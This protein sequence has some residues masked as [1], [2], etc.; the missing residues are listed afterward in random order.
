MPI[1]GDVWYRN[2]CSVS[3]FFHFHQVVIFTFKSLLLR[4]SL[5]RFGSASD[6]DLADLHVTSKARWKTEKQPRNL[7]VTSALGVL[8]WSPEIGPG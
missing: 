5:P 3:I 1:D 8:A 4:M 7:V 2:H 6:R